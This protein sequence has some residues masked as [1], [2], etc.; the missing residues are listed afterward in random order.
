MPITS[1]RRRPERGFTLLEVML[2]AL[3]L[4]MGLMA[5][6]QLTRSTMGAFSTSQAGTMSAHPAI[7]ENMLRDQVELA[8]SVATDS[9]L[10][11]PSLVTPQGTYTSTV[12]LGGSPI[13]SSINWSGPVNRRNYIATVRFQAAGTPAPGVVVGQILFDKNYNTTATGKTGL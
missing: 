4:M 9:A 13:V 12:A 2:T 8:R 5:V 6:S 10:V 3:V 11:L 7:I 1:T